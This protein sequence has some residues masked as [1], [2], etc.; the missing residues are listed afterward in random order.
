MKISRWVKQAGLRYAL[1]LCCTLVSSTSAAADT[2]SRIR[3]SQTVTIAYREASF[4]FSYLNENK[5]PIGYTMDICLK[6]LDA[7]KRELKLPQLTVKYLL[8]T[9]STRIPAIAEGKA[10]LECGSTTN[11]AE[12]R[13]QVSFTIPHFFTTVRM[14]VR[15]DSGIKNWLDLKDK[16]VVTTKGT[17]TV[18]LLTDRDKV[19]ALGLKLIEGNDHNESFK[20]VENFQVDAFPM[21]DVL[22]YGLRANAAD[23]AKFSIIGDPLSTE[24]Y[25]IMLAREDPNFK[26]LVDK[27]IAR[28]MIDGEIGKLYEK[29][30]NRP[31]PPKNANLTMPMSRLLRENI[32]FPSE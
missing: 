2:L 14:L 19:R 11:T 6:L 32:R 21:D 22:L 3:D 24:P 5:K 30:F 26:A 29:W 8:V 15:T 20:M 25:G 18:K 23:P 17:T 16:K 7:L 31:V 27:E 1:A 4:P 13:T 12:R 28:L 10:D 9:S